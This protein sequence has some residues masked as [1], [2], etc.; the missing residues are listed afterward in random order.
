[1]TS[2]WKSDLKTHQTWCK[3]SGE[4]LWRRPMGLHNVLFCLSKMAKNEICAKVLKNLD[5]NVLQQSQSIQQYC[6]IA[7]DIL[8]CDFLP[9]CLLFKT[10]RTHW[11]DN[12]L[13]ARYF[14]FEYSEATEFYRFFTKIHYAWTLYKAHFNVIYQNYTPW[15]KR[16]HTFIHFIL[17]LQ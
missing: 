4:T 1:M 14:Q 3:R 11:F 9:P 7:V 13:I 16:N 8:V 10:P 6:N 15:P 17:L 12:D 5:T 2:R